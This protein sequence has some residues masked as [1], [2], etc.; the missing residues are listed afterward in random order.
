MPQYWG[1]TGHFF[2]LALYNFKMLTA[3]KN[4]VNASYLINGPPKWDVC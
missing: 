1:D 4:F 3:G 2:L